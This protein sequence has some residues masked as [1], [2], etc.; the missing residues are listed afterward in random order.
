MFFLPCG[1]Q[2]IHFHFQLVE[3]FEHVQT[4]QLIEINFQFVENAKFSAITLRNLLNRRQ[5]QHVL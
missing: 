3:R 4:F 5:R 1:I 2:F